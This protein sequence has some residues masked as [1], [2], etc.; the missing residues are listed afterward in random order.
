MNPLVELV[1]GP[2]ACSTSR[3]RSSAGHS[4][5][6]AGGVRDLWGTTPS[7]R[8]RVRIARWAVAPSPAYL[9]STFRLRSGWLLP[10]YHLYRPARF[11]LGMPTRSDISATTRA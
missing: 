9:R 1:F 5:L 6:G 11:A 3:K 4:Q 8:E 2:L 10:L 7:W